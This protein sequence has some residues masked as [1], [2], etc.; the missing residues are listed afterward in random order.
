MK[1]FF[2]FF[3]LIISWQLKAQCPIPSDVIIET[4]YY[5]NI[6]WSENGTATNWDVEYDYAGFTPTGIPTEE[7]LTET[8]FSIYEL[9]TASYDFYVRSD[10]GT[11]QSNWV[12]PFT[13][14][15]YCI[16]YAQTG[17]DDAFLPLCWTQ[18]DQGTPTDEPQNFGFGTWEQ[19]NFANTG[20][21]LSAKIHIQGTEVNDWL[22]TPLIPKDYPIK[23]EWFAFNLEF[24]YA[25]TQHN[26]TDAAVLGSDD[27]IQLVYSLDFGKSWNVL[28]T[29]DSNSSISNTGDSY[30]IYEEGDNNSELLLFAFWVNSGV[31]D[32]AEDIDFFIDDVY[33]MHYGAGAIDYLKAKGFSFSP[34]PVNN[35][36]Y[37]SA[38]EPIS[39][40]V[41]YDVFGRKIQYQEINGYQKQIDISNLT[42]GLYYLQ[43]QI[44]NTVGMV[45]LIKR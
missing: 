8:Q 19:S 25:L 41:L 10:C 2:I 43:V 23:T 4:N 29:W 24:T 44:G 14:Y 1:H 34:N 37:L 21:N 5:P 18:A 26:S 17:F 39:T 9:D 45:K 6:T 20:S 38:K 30:S 35:I 32:D 28:Q 22:L 7:D 11:E 3:I 31:I 13:F 15:N 42:N 27:Q 40:I 16:E 36:L 33:V 12:G